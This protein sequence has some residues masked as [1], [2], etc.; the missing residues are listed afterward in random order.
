MASQGKNILN[1]SL[2]NI[3]GGG[4][5]IPFPVY[6]DLATTTTSNVAMRIIQPFSVGSMF[7]P[8]TYYVTDN[9]L[10]S[11]NPLFSQIYAC[12][13]FLNLLSAG[14]L[15]SVNAQVISNIQIDYESVGLGPQNNEIGF[16]I[17]GIP[18]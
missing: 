7:A 6:L 9:G 12:V 11:G 1:P 2:L 14:N 5:S 8:A 13:P 15:I 10:V 4:G 18:V 3:G 17:L 16:I